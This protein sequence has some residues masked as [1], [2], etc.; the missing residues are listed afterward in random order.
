MILDEIKALLVADAGVLA[1]VS[2]R[3][4]D[5]V[6]PRGYQLPAVVYHTVSAPSAYTLAGDAAPDGI[7]VQFD[8]YA[9]DTPTARRAMEAL[10]DVL[11]NFGGMLSGGSFVQ[12]TFWLTTMDMPDSP[13][14]TAA[15]VG[16]RI[17]AHVKFFYLEATS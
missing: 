4:Y 9:G 6:L 5:T 2:T 3:I 15:A 1:L 16:F 11:Q 12:A 7:T 13:D 10:E 8:V 14:I 17:M